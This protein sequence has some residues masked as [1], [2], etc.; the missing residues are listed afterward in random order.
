MVLESIFDAARCGVVIANY[1]RAT[2]LVP[3]GM[4]ALETFSADSF[5]IRARKIVDATRPWERT[6]FSSSRF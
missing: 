5:L 6:P 4:Q 3:E 2:D 1:V